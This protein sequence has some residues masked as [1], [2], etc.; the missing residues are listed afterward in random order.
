VAAFRSLGMQI[1]TL[2]LMEQEFLDSSLGDLGIRRENLFHLLALY[3]NDG[4]SREELVE[5][6]LPVDRRAATAISELVH[7]GLI[8]KTTFYQKGRS[9]KIFL[10]EKARKME[11]RIR[12]N[13][14]TWN[15]T[16]SN[17][18]TEGERAFL[19]RIL[20]RISQNAQEVIDQPQAKKE[21]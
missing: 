3:E 4:L 10:T 9:W 2:F 19:Q 14:A 6:S 1:S 21:E 5:R 13:L 11:P 17:G 15:S 20:A 7:Q 12:E 18:L 8:K 16:L